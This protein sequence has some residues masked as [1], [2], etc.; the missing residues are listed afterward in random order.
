MLRSEQKKRLQ[1]EIDEIKENLRVINRLLYGEDR[2]KRITDQDKRV[3]LQW[4]KDRLKARKEKLYED[5]KKIYQE[6]TE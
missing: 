2:T 6:P 3:K 4:E 1:A 5:I